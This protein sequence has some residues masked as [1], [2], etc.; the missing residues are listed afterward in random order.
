MTLTCCGYAIIIIFT[1]HIILCYFNKCLLSEVMV[2]IICKP[3][4]MFF[5][6]KVS[7]WHKQTMQVFLQFTSKICKKLNHA[8]GHVLSAVAIVFAGIAYLFII[9]L[10]WRDEGTATSSLPPIKT[11]GSRHIAE[12]DFEENGDSKGILF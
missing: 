5:L 1:H 2:K 8:R 4:Y 11:S 10:F 12:N 3:V 7:I 6:A 9:C